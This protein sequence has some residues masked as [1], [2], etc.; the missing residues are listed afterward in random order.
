M[1]SG[2]IY[3]RIVLA[4][5]MIMPL[6]AYSQ[7]LNGTYT[8]GGSSPNYSS[9]SAA[10]NA[11]NNYGVSGP[12][13][14]NVR[15]GFYVDQIS[16]GNISGASSTNTIV[17]QSQNQDSSLVT[18][19]Y[20]PNYQDNFTIAFNGSKYITFK[21]MELIAD[22][23]S[24]ATAIRFDNNS[25]NISFEN[26]LISG[27]D[28][29]NSSVNLS[30]IY[31]AS[32]IQSLLIKNCKLSKGS[33]GIYLSTTSK[34]IV[35][36]QNT[37]IDQYASAFHC[38]GGD[39]IMIADNNFSS[40]TILSDYETIKLSNAG[41]NLKIFNNAFF[42]N[43]GYCAL[44]MNAC[45]ATDSNIGLI[46]NNCYVSIQ[47][48]TN[49]LCFLCLNDCSY[50]K[51]VYNSAL[52][53]RLNEKSSILL[54][55]GSNSENIGLLNNNFFN[56]SSGFIL[57]LSNVAAIN[58]SN[59]NNFMTLSNFVVKQNNLNYTFAN[60]KSSTSN[61]SNSFRVDPYF[62]SSTD[63]YTQNY[64]IDNKGIPFS[65]VIEDKNGQLRSISSPDIGAYE[66]VTPS[67]D[68]GVLEIDEDKTF[69]ANSDSVYVV[70][71]NFGKD[72][73]KSV[74]INWKVNGQQYSTYYWQGSLA[75][76]SSSSI[77]AIG[78]FDLKPS[79]SYQVSVWTSSPNNKSDGLT[80]NDKLEISDKYIVL[81]GNYTIGKVNSDFTD[82]TSA[83][84]NLTKAGIS[85]NV[86]FYV[87]NG[88]Y[89]EQLSI[90]NIKGSSAN[91]WITFTS[92][93]GD[94]ND[95]VLSFNVDDLKKGFIIDIGAS[96]LRFYKISIVNSS[97][98]NIGGVIR[99]NDCNNVIFENCIIQGVTKSCENVYYSAIILTDNNNS[100][101][102]IQNLILSGSIGCHALDASNDLL[103]KKNIFKDQAY[104]AI[105]IAKVDNL[106]IEQN[107]IESNTTNAN[108][109]AI[110][111][112]NCKFNTTITA[113]KIK[114]ST[115]KSGIE[116]IGNS[117]TDTSKALICNNFISIGGASSNGT[118]MF[119]AS[120]NYINFYYNSINVYRNNSSAYPFYAEKSNNISVLNNIFAR[121]SNGYAVYVVNINSNSWN[122]NAYRNKGLYFASYQ[123]TICNSF[124]DW[125]ALSGFDKNSFFIDP[126]F[127]S[128][129]DLHLCNAKLEGKAFQ[130][131]DLLYDIDNQ[132]R[133]SL[134]P[135]IG[136][137]EF[138]PFTIDLGTDTVSC[139]TITLV[140]GI[141]DKNYL[142]STNESKAQVTVVKPGTYW[143]KV[144]D[145]SCSDV[146]TIILSNHPGT[147]IPLNWPDYFC[148]KNNVLTL[149]VKKNPAAIDYQWII[150]ASWTLDSGQGTNTLF[151]KP[152][153]SDGEVCVSAG[154]SC[155]YGDTFCKNIQIITGM[156]KPDTIIGELKLCEFT[157]N[158]VYQT[159]ELKD[160]ISYIGRYPQLQQY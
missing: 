64:L 78:Y 130:I 67:N 56:A 23:S 85:G 151:V 15:N 21:K 7:A 128:F 136:A 138:F 9:F 39:N 139:D 154:S 41:K 115:G 142:W 8:I 49:N 61:D 16:F 19:Q 51:I 145:N 37:I 148:L 144:Y 137:D 74:E 69:A 117:W 109:T 153:G 35:I 90:V 31:S 20:S 77:L 111:I 34:N 60:W 75:Q 87:K 133:D 146:D 89:N 132:L 158:I 14:F 122:Y 108:Y 124:N 33:Y 11:L 129:T 131:K 94:S 22:G 38:S 140:A 99:Q 73:L 92:Q 102:Y 18:L 147:S 105:N 53:Q 116:L 120:S 68:A 152:S 150:P 134:N 123:G 76:G 125:V 55:E 113:N 47:G 27:S 95:V 114:I 46:A 110:A 101:H 141:N 93:S 156:T 149:E 52:N 88:I 4:C 71:K 79:V 12:V 45:T 100:I 86:V 118:G 54:I 83:I 104:K 72:T 84:T 29:N 66:W 97:Q 28:K 106:K 30:L 112:T 32:S 119:I 40:T 80:F 48:P 103:L 24:Y 62:K 155:A 82:F 81:K 96:Y 42:I 10:V 5:L 25:S 36:T 6:P 160:A 159:P 1:K 98:S 26:C 121:T 126:E 63:L 43:N 13:I 57:T 91:Q 70:I 135:D 127:N 17:F 2:L 143:V 65:D 157:K 44:N 50:Q 59:Y 107:I 3:F 58:Y